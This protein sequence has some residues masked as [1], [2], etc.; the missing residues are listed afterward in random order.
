MSRKY[1]SDYILYSEYLYYNGGGRVDD[2]PYL[3]RELFRGFKRLREKWNRPID[4]TSG[5]RCLKKQK[6]LYEQGVSSTLISVHNFGLGLDLDCDSREEVESMAQTARRV[7]PAF[8]I[9]HHQTARR[10]CPAFRI[11]H[12]A[13]LHRGQ[14]FIHI[15]TGYM[16]SP[17]YSKKLIEGA[18]W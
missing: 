10:V 11:G 4:I 8:R 12:Q 6:E 18:E 14:T 5:Y 17:S 13:Y 16:I 7:C 1:I 3:Y 2:V 15:D 9:G